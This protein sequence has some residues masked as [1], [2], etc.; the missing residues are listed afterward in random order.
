VTSEGAKR[1]QQ[2]QNELGGGDISAMFDGEEIDDQFATKLDKMI[3]DKD[4]PERL[5]LK[6]GE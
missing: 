4:I 5:Q 3:A 6:L 1:K 2:Q